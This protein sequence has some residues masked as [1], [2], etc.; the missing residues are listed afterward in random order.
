MGCFFARV[1]PRLNK[2]IHR[3]AKKRITFQRIEAFVS[4][5]CFRR[6]SLC[7]V[8]HFFFGSFCLSVVFFCAIDSV[9]AIDHFVTKFLFLEGFFCFFVDRQKK[10]GA[11]V[12]FRN[13]NRRFFFALRRFAF[14]R[15]G[16][17]F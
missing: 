14:L 15:N 13:M 2:K 16:F 6:A 10:T 11:K 9:A 1:S 3:D 5:A 4:S 8:F 12:Q 17:F 7:T